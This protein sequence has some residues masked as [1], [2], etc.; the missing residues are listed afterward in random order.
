MSCIQTAIARFVADEDGAT[1]T[2][3]CLLLI[4][5][6]L[7]CIALVQLIGG[8]VNSMFVVSESV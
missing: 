5:V 6:A 8:I 1:L 3:Y 4:L 7:V 2:E